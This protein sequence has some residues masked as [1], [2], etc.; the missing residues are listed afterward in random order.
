MHT[1][2]TGR[3]GEDSLK[4]S[5]GESIPRR[6]PGDSSGWREAVISG[7]RRY[8][9]LYGKPL[10]AERFDEVMSFHEPGLAPAKLGREWFHIRPSGKRAYEVSFDRVWGFYYGLAAVN[11]NGEAFHITPDGL[12][13]YKKRF[14]WVGNFQENVCVVRDFNGNYFHILPDGTRLYRENY[15]YAGDFKEGIASVFSE[16]GTS[17][18]IDKKGVPIYSHRFLDV[19]QFHKGISPARDA[20]GAFH[21]NR[22][23]ERIYADVFSEVEPFYN[24]RARVRARDGRLIT[25]DEKG[26]FLD[27]VQ[28]SGVNP[29]MK[30][31]HDLVGYWKSFLLKAAIDLGIFWLLPSTTDSLSRKLNIPADRLI[32]FLMALR[33]MGYVDLGRRGSW[34]LGQGYEKIAE[35]SQGVL[36]AVSDHWLTQVF[37]SWYSLLNVLRSGYGASSPHRENVFDMIDGKPREFDK[38]QMT[39][40]FYASID[41]R[42]IPELIDF[43]KHRKIIDAGGGTGYLLSLILERAKNSRGYVLDLPSATVLKRNW[44]L[45]GGRISRISCDIFQRWPVKGDAVVLAKVLHDWDDV[46]A[47]MIINRARE[48]LAKNGSLYIVERVLSREDTSGSIL[49]L[50]QYLVNGGRE[51]TLD[52]YAK[53]AAKGGMKVIETLRLSTWMT[54]IHCQKMERRDK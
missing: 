11:R 8:H 52:E 29:L 26:N 6:G 1:E 42:E 50:H 15:R 46:S 36:E 22:S 25:I 45:C 17:F 19:G 54:V 2:E 53:L 38:F 49:S 32:L 3:G 41:Y 23:G 14:S 37:P 9:V 31:S 21:I 20:T 7:D 16:N 5:P 18:H 27:L 28:S 12:P 43:S 24:G 10:Y 48:S 4:S 44:G 30:V 13:A 51:R 39:M 40:E 34:S 35:V 33:E 47:V